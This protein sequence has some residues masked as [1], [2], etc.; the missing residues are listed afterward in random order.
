MTETKLPDGVK[1]KALEW[2]EP[3]HQTSYYTATTVFG[4]YDYDPETGEYDP[5]GGEQVWGMTFEQAKAA[6]QADFNQ[7]VMRCLEVEV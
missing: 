7:R 6:A 5:G 4:V 1:V 3:D 2:E